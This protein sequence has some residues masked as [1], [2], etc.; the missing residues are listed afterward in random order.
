MGSS[1]RS[2]R[3][4]T[5]LARAHE[6]LV[7]ALP[8]GLE[9]AFQDDFARANVRR[10]L[11]IAPLV[12]VGHAVHVVVFHTTAATRATMSPE[13][14]HWRNGVALVHAVT[15]VFTLSLAVAMVLWGR[16]RA[17]RFLGPAAALIY[18]VHGAAIAGVDQLQVMGA[19][20]VAPFI[21]Y[22][23]FMSF[24]VTLTPA[25]AVA[26]Y[27]LAAAVF[28]VALTQMQ[29]L[30]S[31]RMA[32]LPNGIS[33]TL[34]SLV[35]S[36]FFHAARRRDFS[37]RKTIERQQQVLE[38]MNGDLERRV[39]TQVSEIVTRAEEVE[40]LNAQLQGLVRARSSEL[41]IALALLAQRREGDGSLRPGSVLGDRFEVGE[42][43]GQ[44]GMGFVYSGVDRTTGER[45]A[46]KVIQ[47]SS[48]RQLDALHRF[49]REARA[50]ATVS[51]PAIVRALHVDV[52][53]DGMLFQVHEFVEGTTLQRQIEDG[54][55]WD[56]GVAARACAVLCDA[57]A[58][59]HEVGVVHRDV[60]PS[61]IMLTS[62]APGLKLLDFGVAKL[63]EDAR[64]DGNGATGSGVILGTPAYMSPE[65]VEGVRDVT[66]STDLYATGV[67]L[68]RL[69]TG[70]L[71]FDERTL[72]GIAYAHLGATPPDVR[73]IVGRV[74]D[75]LATL[76]ARCLEKDPLTRPS[77]RELSIGLREVADAREAP[78]LTQT[79]SS[80]VLRAA[81]AV[82]PLPETLVSGRRPLSP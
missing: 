49:L 31:V 47:A 60:K 1:R 4:A 79:N 29:P 81:P 22:C 52:T 11:V 50:T 7:P 16:T 26:L 73:T 55:P 68:F 35:L 42:L 75:S 39:A 8:P 3:E 5:W 15:I 74:P 9:S 30:S 21:G 45:V 61:N 72:Q 19:N 76:I 82:G 25:M 58:A 41:S 27:S 77:A 57:L 13:M 69:V 80:R 64:A 53:D 67:I 48:A 63:Y 40:R 66:T 32:L 10:L 44:G 54:K 36:L 38:A 6:W 34:V 20:G 71:P 43:L 18:F 24:V 28:W 17:A 46:I 59:A 62:A 37:Q 33:I 12:L 51:H 2:D 56:A 78:A 65:Q 14:A 70:R 23:L